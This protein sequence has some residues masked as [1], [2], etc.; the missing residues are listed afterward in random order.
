M[1]SAELYTA[2]I[3]YSAFRTEKRFNYALV[4]APKT[5]GRGL[6]QLPLPKQG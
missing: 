6:L 4:T 2:M 3:P 5:K 1:R